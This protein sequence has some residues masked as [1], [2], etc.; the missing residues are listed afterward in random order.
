MLRAKFPD[1]QIHVRRQEGKLVVDQVPLLHIVVVSTDEYDLKWNL[2]LLAKK[3]WDRAAA[4]V[5]EAIQG[6]DAD[7]QWG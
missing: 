3:G 7:V 1:Q 2:P 4:S 5:A 6:T